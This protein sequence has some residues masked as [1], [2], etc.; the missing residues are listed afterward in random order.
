MVAHLLGVAKRKGPLWKG[1]NSDNQSVD[2][3]QFG[4]LILQSLLQEAAP[5]LGLLVEPSTNITIVAGKRDLSP[6]SRLELMDFARGS[7]IYS[8]LLFLPY[9]IFSIPFYLIAASDAA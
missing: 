9:P 1:A 2:A 3:S 8:I 6:L 4:I 7:L 5:V